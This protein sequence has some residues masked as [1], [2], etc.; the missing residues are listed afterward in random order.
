MVELKVLDLCA[1]KKVTNHISLRIG[2]SKNMAPSTGGSKKIEVATSSYSLLFNECVT[3]F[4]K[5]TRKDVPIRQIGISLGNLKDER[6]ESYT[7]FTDYDELEKEKDL[8][9]AII[10]IKNKY[11]K[12]SVLK[13]MN[14]QNNATT[15]K[16]NKL[17]GGHNAS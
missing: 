12:N 6:Y 1:L 9:L 15:I 2:Y 3:L 4:K 17:I 8:Q 11:G 5:T 13:V 14:L 10:K 7:L 16:R